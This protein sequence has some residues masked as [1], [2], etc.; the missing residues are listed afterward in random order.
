MFE[1]ENQSQLFEIENLVL[2]ARSEILGS[3]IEIMCT[4]FQVSGVSKQIVTGRW[5]LVTG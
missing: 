2:W 3:A 4:R 5:L 1:R